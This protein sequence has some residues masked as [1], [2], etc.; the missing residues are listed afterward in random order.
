MYITL[1]YPVTTLRQETLF[2]IGC[3]DGWGIENSSQN[4]WT[5]LTV[6]VWND[7]T[8]R[9]ITRADGKQLTYYANYRTDVTETADL[10]AEGDGQCGSWAKLFIDIRRAQGLTDVNDWVI[11]SPIISDGFL[12][13]NWK[14]TEPG[15][16]ANSNYPYA[17]LYSGDPRGITS[18]IWFS[19]DVTYQSGTPGQGNNKPAAL[20]GNHQ[21]VQIG[22]IYFDPS[23]GVTYD[24]S[25][26]FQ[27]KSLDGFYIQTNGVVRVGKAYSA[28]FIQKPSTVNI[29]PV[30]Y[31]Y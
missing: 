29:I 14:Y 22:S 4:S 26:D 21:T 18:Y 20:F 28:I 1:N 19:A 13:K 24:D 11:F 17:N 3:K 30:S 5:D 6:Q 27:N 15:S 25:G 31:P 16:S 9:Y 2:Y 8:G 10:L 23:Y 12:V 7:F